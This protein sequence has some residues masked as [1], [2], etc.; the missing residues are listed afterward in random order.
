MGTMIFQDSLFGD[1]GRG[2]CGICG[3]VLTN[4]ISIA[5]GIGPICSGKGYRMGGQ[6][7]EHTDDFTDRH[8]DKPLEEGVILQRDQHDVATNVPHLVTQHSPAG[9]EW[10]YGGSGP[11][12]LALNLVEVILLRL[13]HDGERIKCFV[14]TCFSL[15]YTLHQDFKWTFISGFPREGGTISWEKVRDWV[16]ERMPS[17]L[18]F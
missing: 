5:R 14:G 16:H 7:M 9:Y 18:P 15:S 4:P 1:G 3:R 8:I 10:G 6:A 11:A 12:D 13:G 17:P 2:S